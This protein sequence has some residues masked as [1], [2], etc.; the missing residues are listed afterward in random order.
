[1]GPLDAQDLVIVTRHRAFVLL[2][3]RFRRR[4]FR[5]LTGKAARADMGARSTDASLSPP[6]CEATGR[7]TARSGGEG[8]VP[9][10]GR[11]CLRKELLHRFAVPLPI[12]K[13]E[14]GG[15]ATP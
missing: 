9:P 15:D 8:P 7:G 10:H 4:L 6:R 12:R 1:D 13:R 3:C 5:T 14:W 2:P 11:P